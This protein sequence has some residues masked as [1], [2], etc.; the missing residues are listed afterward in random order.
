MSAQNS[1]GSAA[2]PAVGSIHQLPLELIDSC[3][4]SKIWVV[5][6]SE[7]EFVG[8]LKYFDDYVN[9]VLEDVTEL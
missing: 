3:I 4:G 1:S 8:T 6:K 5:M 7:K 9:M 2:A